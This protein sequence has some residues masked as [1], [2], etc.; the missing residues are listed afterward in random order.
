[1]SASVII[2]FH[3]ASYEPQTFIALNNF[4][5]RDFRA[6]LTSAIPPSKSDLRAPIPR[7]DAGNASG[8][9]SWRLQPTSR[10]TFERWDQL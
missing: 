2:T 4:P 1:M 10:L 3:T 6:F 9:S 8:Q 5:R 7:K